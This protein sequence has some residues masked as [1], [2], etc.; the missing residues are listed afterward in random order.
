MLEDIVF[1]R[2]VFNPE[3]LV[4]MD[5]EQAQ[6]SVA[7]GERR[8]PDEDGVRRAASRARKQVFELCA[9]NDLDLF[10]TLTLNKEW[11]D[12]YGY[13]AAVRKF[14]QWADNQVRG[15]GG[16]NTLR[17]R[18]CIKTGRYIFTDCAIR[19]PCALWIAAKKVK[20][21][22][23]IIC[24]VG[25]LVLLRQYLFTGSETLPRTM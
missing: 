21:K 14:G 18:S 23:C 22:R 1:N 10:F 17:C 19:K 9:C 5:A 7:K 6:Y 13:K 3:G 24:P 16:S 12:R 2:D 8:E 4:R 20:G 11:I 25:D 15:G